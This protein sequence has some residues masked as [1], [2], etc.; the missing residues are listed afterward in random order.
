MTNI[1]NFGENKCKN[2]YDYK[3]H[4]Y[5]RNNNI[6]IIY[7]I[8]MT[9]V[10]SKNFLNKKDCDGNTVLHIA[11]QNKNIDI[12]ELL[13]QHGADHS[14]KD[15]K[16]DTAL[17]IAVKNHSDNINKIADLLIKY[18]AEPTLK[19]NKG[20]H[21]EYVEDNINDIDYYFGSDKN[22]VFQLKKS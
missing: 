13:L 22:I 2:C 8:L 12:V 20:E 4:E 19:N 14:L 3:L 15:I 6:E 16:G 17:H 5:V 1:F 7:F 21:I 10:L 18:G 9:E 11:V